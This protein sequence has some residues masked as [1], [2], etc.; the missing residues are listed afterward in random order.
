MN[1]G[2]EALAVKRKKWV[3]ASQE[4]GF[5]EGIKKLLTW[6]YPY[7]THFI[8]ELLQNAEDTHA[9]VVR[10]TLGERALDFE[11]NGPHMF[12]LADVNSITG[13]GISTKRDDPTN[14][15]KFGVGFKA[16]F[17]YTDT[18]EI[19]SGDYHFC[20]SNMVVPDAIDRH[21]TGKQETVFTFPFDHPK[22]TVR[23]AVQEISQ[24]LTALNENTLLFL[25][26]IG[27]IEYL[28][29]DGTLGIQE[30]IE[31]GDGRIE[32]RSSTSGGSTT[33]NHW[34]RFE[35][36]VN[37][38]DDDAPL[39]DC[40]IAIAY[41][42][43]ADDESKKKKAGWKIVPLDQGQ[44][45]IFFPAEKETSNLR[46][47]LHA[48]FASTVSRDSVR[49]CG[50]NN[51]LRDHLAALVV[52]SLGLLRDQGMLD[53]RFLAVLPLPDDKL[54]NFYEPI[55]LAIIKAFQNSPLTPTKSGAHAPAS[56]LYRG[57]T[58]ISD[59]LND[60]DLSYLKNSK[61]PL[62]V[63]NPPQKNQR[64]DRFLD[65]LKIVNWGWD[66]LVRAFGKPHP[67]AWTPEQKA[68]NA[69]YNARIE[70][71]IAQKEDVWLIKLKFLP[72]N[73]KFPQ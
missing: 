57:P 55:R 23:E 33:I 60:G 30:R 67:Q 54:P 34:L 11:H 7:K 47:H 4:N 58:S 13:M 64:E 46:F 72:Q 26:W 59:V 8:Y 38:K 70:S 25:R 16:V 15:G 9:S 24:G 2:L 20:I 61:T 1:D 50:A 43:E 42:L 65:C 69:S 21:P 17:A 39:K 27:K 45:S 12:S 29:P 56:L 40:H 14:I 41:R 22:K 71:W 52:E 3:D 63:A 6:I 28:L 31:H 51:E 32:I 68:E 73:P 35:K 10:F 5:E 37:V 18:P 48:P 19:R 44:V 53:V 49:D 62:W 36:S 66:A